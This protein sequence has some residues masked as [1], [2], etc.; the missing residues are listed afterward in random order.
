MQKKTILTIKDFQQFC[1]QDLSHIALDFEATSLD[2]LD[3]EINGWSICNGESAC[4]VDVAD[5][6]EK[7]GLIGQIKC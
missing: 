7:E 4:Y 2:Y 6:S 3:L 1:S 5:N